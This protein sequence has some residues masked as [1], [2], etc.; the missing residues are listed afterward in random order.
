MALSTLN[1][2]ILQGRGCIGL[3]YANVRY[4]MRDVILNG[5]AYMDTSLPCERLEPT[6]KLVSPSY[7]NQV[8]SVAFTFV[9]LRQI[10]NYTQSSP[11]GVL[12]T[13]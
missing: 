2:H 8:V 6:R 10:V 12:G 11:R 1:Y 3:T 4:T 7:A 9:S 5:Q 13:C